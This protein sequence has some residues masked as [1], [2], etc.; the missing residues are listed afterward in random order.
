MLVISGISR[1][2]LIYSYKADYKSV[3]DA[4]KKKQNKEGENLER[5][6]SREK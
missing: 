3:S 1:I 2:F 5:K 6:K 4:L